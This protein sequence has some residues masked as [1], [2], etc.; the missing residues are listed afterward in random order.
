[1]TNRSWS[2]TIFTMFRQPNRALGWVLAGATVGLG[3][4]LSVPFLR[5]LFHFSAPGLLDIMI[6][7]A[8]GLLSVCWFEM[9]K[10][11]NLRRQRRATE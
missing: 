1:M 8:A 2:Q 4:I 9:V 3:L 10:I 11:I 5:D 7:V 6:C